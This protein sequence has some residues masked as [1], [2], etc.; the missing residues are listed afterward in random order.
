MEMG[1]EHSEA[2][3]QLHRRRSDA[4]RSHGSPGIAGATIDGRTAMPFVRPPSPTHSSGTGPWWPWASSARTSSAPINSCVKVIATIPTRAEDARDRA[5]DD[6]V[7]DPCAPYCSFSGHRLR[8]RLRQAVGPHLASPWLRNATEDMSVLM[9]AYRRE[10][11][12]GRAHPEWFTWVKSYVDWL[13]QQQRADGSFPR[14]WKPGSN[15]VAEAIRNH[16]L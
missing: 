14:R 11:A 15:E 16:Q 9:R 10:R 1:L 8:F 7:H 3:R 12:Q 13:I 4:P 6:L 5:G 2:A